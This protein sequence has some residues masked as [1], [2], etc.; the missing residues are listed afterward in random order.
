MSDSN[1][2]LEQA[3]HKY[4]ESLEAGR[5]LLERTQRFRE[6]PENRSFAY[7][8]LA[9][10]QAMAYN[11]AIAPRPDFPRVYV[12]TTWLTDVFTLG[13]NDAS[14]YYGALFLD[15]QKT[16]RM[17]GRLGDVRIMTV[18]VANHLFGT[19]DYRFVDNREFVPADMSADGSLELVFSATQQAGNWVRLD[20]E[21]GYNMVTLRRQMADWFDDE[22]AFTVEMLSAPGGDEEQN[23][24]QMAERISRAADFF[25]YAIKSWV[26][27]I[28][29]YFKGVSGGKVNTI[30]F[31]SPSVSNTGELGLSPSTDYGSA[32][33]EL[34]TDQAII[35]E[36][37]VP[38]NA[39]YW[40][41]QLFDVWGK[42]IDFVYHQSDINMNRAVIDSDGRFRAVISIED[43]GVPN[44]LDPKGRKEGLFIMRNY[45]GSTHPV[46][47]LRVVKFTDLTKYLPTDTPQMTPEQ[48][49]EV[50]D[51]RRRGFLRLYGR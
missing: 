47:T 7:Y 16:Y 26:I 11:F 21:S 10:A 1:G 13:G 49:Q 50:L 22:G 42:S 6:H 31:I 27:G 51:H 15:G 25:M 43:P 33:F 32:I 45:R 41:F 19:P 18:Q 46:P 5:I 28:Y 29:D 48:R 8:C 20:P 17:S 23:P 30:G 35:I 3:W 38:E 40:S 9:E 2:L 14:N 12:Q 24:K 36:S 4:Y 37:D 39:V 44:W 34:Q